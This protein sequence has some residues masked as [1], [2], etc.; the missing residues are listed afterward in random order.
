[1]ALQVVFSV[2]PQLFTM[3]THIIRCRAC[4]IGLL[5]LAAA[6]TSTAFI[7]RNQ[8]AI[9]FPRLL[10]YYSIL[11]STPVVLVRTPGNRSQNWNGSLGLTLNFGF[12]V[13]S[14]FPDQIQPDKSQQKWKSCTAHAKVNEKWF[15]L[16][17]YCDL[18]RRW[19]AREKEENGDV[20]HDA[21]S[22]SE[23]KCRQACPPEMK[24]SDPEKQSTF[25]IEAKWDRVL[26]R[27]KVSF[28]AEMSIARRSRLPVFPWPR[29][30]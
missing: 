13:L 25:F 15:L 24:Q 21:M 5:Q 19:W 9:R 7:C 14:G 8:R 27:Q 30:P 11:I 3:H 12:E 6:A 4:A 2:Q 23:R 20:R 22:S 29:Q 17:F 18:G 28:F 10:R 16:Y 26:R 1:M